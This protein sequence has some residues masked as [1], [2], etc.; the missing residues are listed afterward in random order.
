ME[1][2]P[3]RSRPGRSCTTLSPNDRAI[4]PGIRVGPHTVLP[5]G[6]VGLGA[7]RH[8][9]DVRLQEFFQQ[10]FDVGLGVEPNLD[11]EACDGRLR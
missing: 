9:D 11:A 3:G 5:D 7:G 1:C 10:A 6:L 8:D 4:E 2:T